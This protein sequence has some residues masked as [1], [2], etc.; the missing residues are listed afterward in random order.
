MQSVRTESRSD[1]SFVL[2]TYSYFDEK[3]CQKKCAGDNHEMWYGIN[4]SIHCSWH[5]RCWTCPCCFPLT[6]A[7]ISPWPLVSFFQIP[8]NKNSKPPTIPFCIVKYTF[9]DN[10]PRNFCKPTELKFPTMLKNGR[11][12]GL[13]PL[14]SNL[15]CS[16]CL[17]Y[18]RSLT[19]RGQQGYGY[20]LL[21]FNFILGSN[22]IFLLFLGIVMY[23][24]E[25][26]TKENNII[27]NQG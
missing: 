2:S 25:F 27:L 6:L 20:M 23:D 5:C 4:I 13:V 11:L 21:W 16:I 8:S 14:F 17:C 18:L 26:Q 22:F 12:V 1:Y 24:N 19:Y 9:S 3:D 10:L 15:N 7:N